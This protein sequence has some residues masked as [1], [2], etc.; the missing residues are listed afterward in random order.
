MLDARSRHHHSSAPP[1]RSA[2]RRALLHRLQRPLLS[3]VAR[4][5]ASPP[6]RDRHHDASM[7]PSS[8]LPKAAPGALLLH[9]LHRRTPS[10]IADASF[11]NFFSATPAGTWSVWSPRYRWAP[12][13]HPR[14]TSHTFSA[15]CC[16]LPIRPVHT[17]HTT[18]TAFHDLKMASGTSA[19]DALRYQSP[20]LKFTSHLRSYVVLRRAMGL[21]MA[22]K[23]AH[24]DGECHGPQPPH[25]GPQV[26]TCCLH[27][28]CERDL[29][30][31]MRCSDPAEN[32]MEPIAA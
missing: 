24:F 22:R 28:V 26:F 13:E 20:S 19:D 27:F 32:T 1:E 16:R 7:N 14:D 21:G 10:C 4:I 6:N 5:H 17:T 30:Q 25:R 18:Y 12:P 8:S 23:K 31:S 3:I 2:I 11:V 15:R 29:P 9:L